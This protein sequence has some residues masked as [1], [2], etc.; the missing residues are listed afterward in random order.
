MPDGQNI[1]NKPNDGLELKIELL[2]TS[3]GDLSRLRE[4]DSICLKRYRKALIS[5][6][7]CEKRASGDIVDIALKALTL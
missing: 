7:G 5:I 3:L 2:E 4:H 6:A 1:E